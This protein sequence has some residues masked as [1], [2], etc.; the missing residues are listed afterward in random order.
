MSLKDKNENRI[1]LFGGSFN[2]IHN[3]HIAIAEAAANEFGID[4][5]VLLPNKTTYY[6]EHS[7]RYASDEDRVRML[8]I[9]AKA[10]PFL[11]V[12]DMEI[13]RGGVTRTID[14]VDELLREDR[15]RKIYLI[16]G[17][18][19]LD[20]IDK[21]V[22]AERLLDNVSL[23]VAM[24][25]GMDEEG[26]EEKTSILK[27][28]HPDLEIYKLGLDKIDISSSEIRSRVKNGQVIEGMVPMDIIE[29]IV[30]RGLYE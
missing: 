9:V 22:D 11:S 18:D 3:G 29:Y 4:N 7:D 5:I 24:R 26:F 30:Y 12:N 25:K 16:I 15:D 27:A 19:S 2:P 6:K 21:W 10:Y 20:W 1:V 8:E 13:K 17:T 14:T 23:I 28:A